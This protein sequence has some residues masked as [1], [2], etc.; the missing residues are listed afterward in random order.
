MMQKHVYLNFTLF[1]HCLMI[2]Y[3]AAFSASMSAFAVSRKQ[4]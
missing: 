4:R 2:S 3:I 1:L